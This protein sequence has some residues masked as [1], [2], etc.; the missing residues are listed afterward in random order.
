M[1]LRAAEKHRSIFYSAAFTARATFFGKNVILRQIITIPES[2]TLSPSA[3][4]KDL[5]DTN[6]NSRN[7]HDTTIKE[8]LNHGE[9]NQPTKVNFKLNCD[10]S[11]DITGHEE[12]AEMVYSA[13]INEG[14][15]LLRKKRR[16]YASKILNS[17]VFFTAESISHA[18]CGLQ[19]LRSLEAETL[20]LITVLT[21]KMS[22][23]LGELSGKDIGDALFGMQGMNSKIPEVQSMI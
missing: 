1:L 23:A 8:V 10:V 9:P 6:L 16:D 4:L 5:T 21:K 18:L 11:Q 17:E 22:F 19:N 20:L 2:L 3:Q 15:I 14:G 13:G 12:I 7:G